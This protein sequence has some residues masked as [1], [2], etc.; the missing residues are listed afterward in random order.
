MVSCLF[1][2][3]LLITS[4]VCL[5]VDKKVD[6]LAACIGQKVVGAVFAAVSRRW[7][8]ICTIC[9]PMGSNKQGPIPEE[10]YQMLLTNKKQLRKPGSSTRG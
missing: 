1:L 4:G 8:K 9:Q 6:W 2:S 5:F 10:I 3:F 7:R